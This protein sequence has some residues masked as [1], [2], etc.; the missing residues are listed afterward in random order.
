MTDST[1][2]D[3]KKP[4]GYIYKIDFPNDKVYIGITTVTLKRRQ[5]QHK[6]CAGNIKYTNVLYCALRKHKMINSFKLELIDTSETDEELK[7]K[8]M[9]YIQI[10]DSYYGNNKGY[11]MTLG[12]D[13]Q[14][15]LKRN[16]D[17]REKI[18]KGLINYH[19]KN[20]DAGKIHGAKIKKLNI[21]DPSRIQNYSNGQLNFHR[22]NPDAGKITGAKNKK[23]NAEDPSRIQNMRDARLNYYQKNP[24]AG[25]IHGAKIKKLNAED[26]SRIEN[27]R[28]AQLN[29]H[30]ENPDAGLKNGAKIKERNIEDP[31]R[32][33][34]YSKG[35]KSRFSK[36]EEKYRLLDAQNRNKPFDVFTKDGTFIKTFTYQMDAREYL[37]KEHN[38]TGTIKIGEV[39][40][41]NRKSSA[42]FV[43]KYK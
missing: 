19:Q 26:P 41:G 14:N 32:L 17:L 13:G 39:L 9:C 12:G 35:Q 20:P 29:F 5:S 6:N 38:I 34:N 15:G 8:E 40:C 22:K 3:E 42:G 18:S 21:E 11:N 16:E 4:Y 7:E 33:E 36:V 10:Y 24:D 25:K 28:D 31:S 23:L 27:N 1:E 37:K 2:L 43:F 30:R